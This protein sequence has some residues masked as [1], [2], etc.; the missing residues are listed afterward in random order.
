MLY[1][2]DAVMDRIELTGEPREG[3]DDDQLC[4]WPWAVWTAGVQ[5]QDGDYVHL[6]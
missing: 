1:A 5:T 4:A 3:D 6:R 2:D